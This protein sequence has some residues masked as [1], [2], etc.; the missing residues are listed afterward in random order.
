MIAP[1]LSVTDTKGVV[2]PVYQKG[3]AWVIEIAGAT[4]FLT[5]GN[6]PILS[7]RAYVRNM[8]RNTSWPRLPS[9]LATAKHPL[10]VDIDGVIVRAWPAV[11]NRDDPPKTFVHPYWNQRV[12]AVGKPVWMFAARG[13]ETSACGEAE[14]TQGLK[15]VE[16]FAREW[17]K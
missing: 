12:V 2:Y 15:D 7:A 13:R 6:E 11:L 1:R 4:Y 16:A 5:A 3:E 9:W 14:R 10:V 17:L 8:P